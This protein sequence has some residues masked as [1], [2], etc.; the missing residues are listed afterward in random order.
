VKA[1]ERLNSQLTGPKAFPLERMFAI[2]YNIV[3]VSVLY[4][5]FSPGAKGPSM[6][7]LF[8]Q[9]C[10]SRLFFHTDPDPAYQF[11][12]DPDP[13][14]QLIRRIRVFDPNRDPFHFKELM[15]L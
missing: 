13:A 11:D 2:F 6:I 7:A 3:D 14:F 12:L 8:R 10:G 4:H 1:K 9:C 15:R 5:Q